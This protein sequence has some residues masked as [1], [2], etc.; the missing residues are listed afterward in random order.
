MYA[1]YQINSGQIQGTTIPITATSI[2]IPINLEYQIVD[3][4]ELIDSLFVEDATQKSVNPILDYDKVRFT[5]IDNQ[6]IQLGNISYNINF[7]N[8][9]NSLQVPTYYSNIGFED[10]DI[11]FLKNNF[12][13]S[14]L[15]LEFYD[16]D[17]QMTQNQLLTIDIYNRLSKGDYYPA[18]T[19]GANVA[20]QP[21]PASQIPVSLLISNPLVIPK[22]FYEGYYIYAYKD[23]MIVNGN[24]KYMYMKASYFNG[25]TGKFTPLSTISAPSKINDFIKKQY[26][27]YDLYRN[28]TGFYYKISDTHSTNVIY[29]QNSVTPN[30]QDI[31]VNLY[32]SQVL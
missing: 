31:T 8:S 4:S 22:A 29:R 20:G 14:Y 11:K 30:N 19:S 15:K 25:K 6:N 18:G 24:P 23:D 28:T 10:S 21:L 3:N 32:Q 26:T 2:S 13:E 27:R 1:K 12:T 16:S 7:L 17:N 5:P 9:S